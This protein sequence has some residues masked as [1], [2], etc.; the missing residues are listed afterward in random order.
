MF[1]DGPLPWWQRILLG[2][3]VTSVWFG[4]ARLVVSL[5][6][7]WQLAHPPKVVVHGVPPRPIGR[8]GMFWRRYLFGLL[9]AAILTLGMWLF[10]V[11][12]GQA[13]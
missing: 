1:A 9:I 2:I 7:R 4:T 13:D 8:W 3:V 5:W 12:T 11:L 10:A 6:A